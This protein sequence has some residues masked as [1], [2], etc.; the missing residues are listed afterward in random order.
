MG[1]DPQIHDENPE[2]TVEDFARSRNASE[3]IGAKRAAM[4]VRKGGRPAKTPGERK[5][6]VT[7]RMAPD[8]LGKLR[9]TGPGWQAR[10]ENVL[11]REF[12]GK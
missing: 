5:Q 6:Q 7:M 1:I 10:A 12:L 2:W 9:A 3:V 4:L 8:L 11:R